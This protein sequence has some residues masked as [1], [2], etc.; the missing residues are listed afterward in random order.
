MCIPTQPIVVFH[1][2]QRSG[3]REKHYQGFHC[4]SVKK[5]YINIKLYDVFLICLFDLQDSTC[6]LSQL[7]VTEARGPG[8]TASTSLQATALVLPSGTT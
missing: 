1:S 4:M 2:C 6:T 5:V 8:S 7:D 3:I